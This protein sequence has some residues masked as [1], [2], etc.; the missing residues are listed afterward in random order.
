MLAVKIADA[1]GLQNPTFLTDNST[2]AS[3]AAMVRSN[4]QQAPWEIR[5][6][7]IH[8]RNLSG[9]Q[10][11][12]IKRDLNGVAHNCAHQA[13]RQSLSQ[14]IFSCSCSA[15]NRDNCPVILA[16]QNLHFQGIVIHVVQCL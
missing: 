11:F 1:L 2:L 3:S 10:I 15:H 7:L 8:F 5:R 13:L 6:H 14:P 16:C 9:F 4:L 12:H